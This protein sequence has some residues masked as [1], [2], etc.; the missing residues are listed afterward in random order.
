M[1]TKLVTVT[2][3]L[4]LELPKETATQDITLDLEIGGQIKINDP[5][6]RVGVLK[7]Y[8]TTWCECDED[9][10]E[11]DDD[12]KQVE[13]DEHQDQSQG[14]PDPVHRPVC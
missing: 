11:D 4:V 2:V 6:A 12:P 14:E 5:E 10:D 13:V 8:T 1:E 9:D 3:D 7:S